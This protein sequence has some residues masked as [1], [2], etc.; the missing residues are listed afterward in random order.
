MTVETATLIFAAVF[1]VTGGTLLLAALSRVAVE[2]VCSFSPP[3]F[4]NGEEQVR[5]ILSFT[6]LHIEL[7][8]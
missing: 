7:G 4:R 6:G 3:M 5:R 8:K 2:S 1:N